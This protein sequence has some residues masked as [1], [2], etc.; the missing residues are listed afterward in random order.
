MP[1]RLAGWEYGKLSMRWE[2]GAGSRNLLIEEDRV[3]PITQ[4]MKTWTISRRVV[5][6]YRVILVLVAALAGT[7][8]L[9]LRGI[10]QQQDAFMR[11]LMAAWGA[12]GAGQS[13][14]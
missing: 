5:V 1:Q 10:Q 7:K 3:W 9:L 4:D 12:W 14:T 13:S 8:A 11:A 2:P 6:G